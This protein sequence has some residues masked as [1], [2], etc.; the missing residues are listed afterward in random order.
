MQLPQNKLSLLKREKKKKKKRSPASRQDCL[1]TP[2]DKLQARTRRVQQQV[3]VRAVLEASQA[4][5]TLSGAAH[6]SYLPLLL[7]LLQLLLLLLLW[8]YSLQLNAFDLFDRMRIKT[9]YGSR[10]FTLIRF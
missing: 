4:R 2:S 6:P 10:A 7:L 1:V 9:R 5:A 8:D 3:R